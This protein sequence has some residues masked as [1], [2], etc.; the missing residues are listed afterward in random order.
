MPAFVFSLRYEDSANWAICKSSGLIGVRSSPSAIRSAA[1][2]RDGDTIFVWRG[3]GQ[4]P[5]SGLLAM[6]TATDRARPAVNA[7]WPDP[8][9]YTYVVPFTLNR[10]LHKAIP[11]RFPD[12]RRG[13]QFGI[14]NTDLQKGLR[15]LSP[16]SVAKLAACFG[17]ATT[18]G[19]R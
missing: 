6:I 3:G 5:G 1:Q 4:R 13:I 2:V 14:Q 8:E 15:P 7:P 12:N 11:D 9:I 18:R 19:P 16:D 17:G 10:E